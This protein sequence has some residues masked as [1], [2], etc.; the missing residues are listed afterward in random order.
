MKLFNFLLPL[1][2]SLFF[3]SASAQTDDLS[4]SLSIADSLFNARQYT[5]A[6]KIYGAIYETGEKVSPAM[7]LR[8]SYIYEG[9]NKVPDALYYL[10]LYYL[11]TNNNAALAK[12][13]EL[14]DKYHLTGYD[15]DGFET[16][17][18][19]YYNYYD[20]IIIGVFALVILLFLFVLFNKLI[21]KRNSTQ[22]GIALVLF[23][24]LLFYLVNFGHS[25]KQGI[26]ENSNCYLMSAPSASSDVVAIVD[27]GHKVKIMDHKDVWVK[28]KFG[29]KV[30][31]TKNKNIR[32]IVL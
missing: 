9:L 3:T 13:K 14:A 10:D 25:S 8:M 21:L 16:V 4:Q 17:L 30:V 19:F 24:G 7:L 29:D 20:N 12:M 26:I 2:L 1:F 32:P 18:R 5:Q 11:E 31:Y 23:S 27:A 22:P 6:L 28:I 15:N